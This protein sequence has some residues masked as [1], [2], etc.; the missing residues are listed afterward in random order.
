[1]AN[2]DKVVIAHNFSAAFE[3]MCSI[4]AIGKTK[5]HEETLEELILQC[6]VCLPDDNFIDTTDYVNSIDGLFGLSIAPHEIQFALDQLIAK[7]VLLRNQ[8]NKYIVRHEIKK[9][10]NRKIEFAQELQAKIYEGWKIEL[11]GKYPKI[12][13]GNAWKVLQKYLAYA[14]QRHGIQAIALLDPATELTSN[15]SKSLSSILDKVVKEEFPEELYVFARNAIS[16]FMATTGNYPERAKY[17]SQL[18]DGAFNYY[19]LTL[20]PE[21]ADNFKKNLNELSLFLDTNFLFGILDL[22]VNPQVAVSN[23]LITVIKTYDLPF[24]LLAHQATIDELL[25]SISRYESD[26]TERNWSRSI[27]RVASNSRLLS[28]VEQR[29]HQRYANEGVDVRSF[30]KP[31]KHADVILKEKGVTIYDPEEKNSDG[32]F[33]LITQYEKF[34]ADRGKTKF[35]KLIEHDM[36]VLDQVRQL[37]KSTTSTLDAGA[38]LIT[39]DYSVY[40]F[41][42]E[43]SKNNLTP[44]CTVLPNIFWQILRPFIPSSDGFDKAFA[45]TF[46]IPEF[47]ILGSAASEACSKMLNILAG[48]KDFPEETATRMLSNDLLIEGLQT[49]D[50]DKEFQAFIELEI[51]RDNANLLKE[52]EQLINKINEEKNKNIAIEKSFIEEFETGKK[53]LGEINNL[54]E[55]LGKKDEE[56]DE[57]RV[58]RES[59]EEELRKADEINSRNEKIIKWGAFIITSIFLVTVI[60]LIIN[61]LPVEFIIQHQNSTCIQIAISIIFVLISAVIFFKKLN[62]E[63]VLGALLDGLFLIIQLLSD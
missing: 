1:M 57:E 46:A 7:E 58:A 60:V 26:L 28:G 14:F 2:S 41:D 33:D 62:K 8:G 32:K 39:C 13:F 30:F 15:Y 38:L 36:T 54:N 10:L 19:N 24:K 42:W 11:S 49:I 27:S 50:D 51:V 29:Y 37:R 5:T 55:T 63:I 16:E 3:Q 52:K 25:S 6:M 47:R 20:P 21:V 45:E 53:L 59:I 44:A 18:A 17:I 48:Y 56:L 9:K 61:L 40:K 34:L 31:Y 43:E 4:V 12:E 35:H 22:T 23:E